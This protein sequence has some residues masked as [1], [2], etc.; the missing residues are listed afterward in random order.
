MNSSTYAFKMAELADNA[1]RPPP[2]AVVAEVAAPN[3]IANTK[4]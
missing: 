1:W 2:P 4:S 3:A